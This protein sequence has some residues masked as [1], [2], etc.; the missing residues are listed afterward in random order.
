MIR[1]ETETI[2]AEPPKRVWQI[3]TDFKSFPEWNPLILEMEGSPKLKAKLALTVSAPDGSDTTYSFKAVIVNFQP[4]EL[5]AWKGG[6]PGILSGLHYWRLS[7]CSSGT[8]LVHG[9]D[10]SG[11]YVWFVGCKHIL[12]FS[13]AYEAM[14]TALAERALAFL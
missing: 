8:H 13:P 4:G 10:F 7:P 9:E 2:I 5:L 14:N 12:L 6:V 1:L 3:L 11:L